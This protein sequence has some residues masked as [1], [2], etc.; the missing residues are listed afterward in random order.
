[1]RLHSVRFGG[2][3]TGVA[4]GGPGGVD[5]DFFVDRAFSWGVGAAFGDGVVPVAGGLVVDG[6]GLPA[7]PGA[8]ATLEIRGATQT[9]ALAA[10]PV[11][12]VARAKSR[13]VN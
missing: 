9:A 10:T 7:S 3:T 11:L 12:K 6:G 13:R 5:P 1:V 2:A 8:S 4:A